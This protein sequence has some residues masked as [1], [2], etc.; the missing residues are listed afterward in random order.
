MQTNCAT[1]AFAGGSLPTRGSPLRIGEINCRHFPRK[2]NEWKPPKDAN[3][4]FPMLPQARTKTEVVKWFRFYVNRVGS[5]LPITCFVVMLPI[6]VSFA[7]TWFLFSQS[8]KFASFRGMSVNWVIESVVFIDLKILRLRNKKFCYKIS[9][10]R[11][12]KVN[13]IEFLAIPKI[14][15]VIN[16]APAFTTLSPKKGWKVNF[17]NASALF[18]DCRHQQLIE[19]DI[20]IWKQNRYQRHWKVLTAWFLTC[21][22]STS[23]ACDKSSNVTRS[24]TSS[25][26]DMGSNFKSGKF[27]SS[28]RLWSNAIVKRP[29]MGQWRLV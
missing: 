6:H 10:S 5:N 13:K 19:I 23:A 7:L 16:F 24:R 14:H 9:S 2:E 22:L 20:W 4:L 1:Q 12:I 29:F 15:V 26:H 21:W 11:K 18:G 27:N 28:C 8:I 17:F 25:L 3:I